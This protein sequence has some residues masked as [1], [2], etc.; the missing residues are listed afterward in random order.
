MFA[1]LL[2]LISFYCGTIMRHGQVLYA[3]IFF[4]IH[5]F[6]QSSPLCSFAAKLLPII[7]HLLRMLE[8]W[9][10]AVQSKAFS[11]RLFPR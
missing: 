5:E 9:Y 7:I 1:D 4:N 10:P 2:A 6:V 8:L 3:P 11:Y